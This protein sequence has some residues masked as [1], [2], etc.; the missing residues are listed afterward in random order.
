MGKPNWA[1]VSCGM[2]SS[3]K[4]SV[5][6]HIQNIHNGNANFVSFIDYLAGR[7]S[8]YYW[9]GLPPTY[10]KKNNDTNKKLNYTNIMKEELFRQSIRQKMGI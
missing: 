9:P 7:K 8:G 1:C 6:R 5:K 3:R 4:S 10:Q 2:Y